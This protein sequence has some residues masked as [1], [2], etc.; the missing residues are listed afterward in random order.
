MV[1]PAILAAVLTAAPATITLHPNASTQVTVS[2]SQGMLQGSSAHALVT[3]A[4]DPVQ[5]ATLDIQSGSGTGL[6][7]LHVTDA[8]GDSIDIPVH[9]A[10]DAGTFPS[11]VSLTVTGSVQW[12]WLWSQI[13]TALARASSVAPGAMLA[14]ASPS[15]LPDPPL[16]G[17]SE[18][19]DTAVT[20]GGS[21]AFFQAN[22]TVHV[23]VTNAPVEPVAPPILLYD[24]DPERVSANG[25]IFR[26]D[27]TSENAAR[28]YYYHDDGGDPRRLAVVIS[29]GVPTDV[30]AIDSSAGPNL[31]V[32]SVGHAVSAGALELGARNEGVVYHLDPGAPLVLHDVLMT[33]KQGVAGSIAFSVLSGGPLHVEVLSVAP[34]DDVISAMNGPLLPR[35]GHHRSGAFEITNFGATALAYA[36]GGPDAMVKYGGRSATPVNAAATDGLDLGDYGVV[37]TMLFSLSNPQSAPATAYLYERPAGGIV[38]STFLVDGAIRQIGCVRDQEKRY[39]IAAFELAA[40]AKYQLNVQTMTDGGSSYPLEIGI[41]ATPPEPAAPPISSPEGCFPKNNR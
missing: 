30:Q 4:P 20:I 36:A 9:V 23:N 35:D 29:A 15:P 27:I 26:A 34:G 19:F 2:G 32:L 8:A 41:T 25:P 6:D 11:A 3:V 22:G 24:D 1:L 5:P 21:D 28:L 33:Q 14:M 12:P 38:R 13:Q 10:R 16:A 39:Q 40:G 18:A 31:D 17:Q 7:T 37:H